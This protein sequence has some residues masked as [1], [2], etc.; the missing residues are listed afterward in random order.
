MFFQKV[1]RKVQCK[2]CP[3]ECIL[4]EGNTGLCGV[5]QNIGGKIKTQNYGL[6][7]ALAFDPI[8]KKPLYHF[9]PGS[10]ILSVGSYGCNLKCNFCQNWEISQAC[11]QR[12]IKNLSSN[13]YSIEQIISSAKKQ[14][15]NIGIAFTYNEP[16]VGFEYVLDVASEAKKEGLKTVMVTNGFI[17]QEPLELLL[18]KIDA[19]N[20]DLKAFTDSFYSEMTGACITPVKQSIQTIYKRN[21]HLE[22]TYLVIP[23]K[24]DNVENFKEMIEWISTELDENVVLHLSRYFPRYKQMQPA[25][26]DQTL[27]EFFKLAKEK[28][29]FVYVGNASK[30]NLSD[31]QCSFCNTVIVK[32][33]AYDIDIEFKS[34][35]NCMSCKSILNHI[36]TK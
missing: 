12:D 3:H 26:S 5:R 15:R 13:R 29:N 19:L 9:Y 14:D 17:N 18:E 24:N 33:N 35:E 28:L 34:S 16:T 8:E 22:I 30:L 7:S 21:R 32:R 36:I 10:K 25:T 11:S 20:I 2:V 27:A 31:T 6:I 1:K 23:N 4:Q